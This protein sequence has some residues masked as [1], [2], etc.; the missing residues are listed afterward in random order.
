MDECAE[1]LAGLDVAGLDGYQSREF[2]EEFARGHRLTGAG[3]AVLARRVD[4]TGSFNLS[5]HRSA[6]HYLAKVSGTSVFAAEQ[7]IRTAHVVAELPATEAALRA[8]ELSG[9]QVKEVAA[10]AAADPSAEPLLLQRASTDGVKGLKAEA[11]RVIAAASTD[12]NAR[13]ERIMRERTFRHWRDHDGAGRIDVRGPLDL[14][15]RVALALAPYEQELFAAATDRDESVRNDALMFDALVALADASTGE[16]PKGSGPMPTVSVRIDQR[17]FLSGD[18]EPGEVCEIVGVGPIPVSVAQRLADDAF[19]KAIMTTGVDVL[20]V[21]HL[22]RTIPAHLRTA[23]DE[24]FPE[25]SVEGCNVAWSLEIDHNQPVEARG[26]TALWNLNKLCRYHHQLK[27]RL[28]LRL[29]GHGTTKRLV[30]AAE[31]HPPDRTPKGQPPRR[32]ALVAA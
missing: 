18:T 28:D 15:T 10:A 29:V 3:V 17:A 6:A 23:L 24:L 11:A 12:E 7:T 1:L 26:P 27:T 14:T 16:M 30:P 22:G 13:Y 8:G 32:R 25:C 2:M 31:W 9:V 4:E 21:S 5:Q 20:A 19:L